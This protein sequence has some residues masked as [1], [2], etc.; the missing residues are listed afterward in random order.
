MRWCEGHRS[1][2]YLAGVIAQQSCVGSHTGLVSPA[3]KVHMVPGFK[4]HL[5]SSSKFVDAGYAWIFD[6]EEVSICD[7][8]NTKTTMSS[9]LEQQ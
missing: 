8:A 4:E 1:N 9:K 5:Q 3:K 2:T 6:Q 7:K